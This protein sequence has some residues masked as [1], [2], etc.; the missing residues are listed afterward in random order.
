MNFLPGLVCHEESLQVSGL[1]YTEWRCMNKPERESDGCEQYITGSD[2]CE[3]CIAAR[4][5]EEYEHCIAARESEGC[6]NM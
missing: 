5:S 2:G 1:V 4:E 6:E 3:Q